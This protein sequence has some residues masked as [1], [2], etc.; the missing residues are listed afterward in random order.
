MR[1]DQAIEAIRRRY[2]ARSL[3]RGAEAD[4]PRPRMAELIL[5]E[6]AAPQVK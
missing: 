3:A 5:Q 4:L 6:Q 1:L 2:G